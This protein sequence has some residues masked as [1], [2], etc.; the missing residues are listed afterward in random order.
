M[1]PWI[2]RGGAAMDHG[3]IYKRS[4]H[5]LDPTTAK[6]VLIQKEAKPFFKMIFYHPNVLLCIWLFFFFMSCKLV[7]EDVER[8][9]LELFDP[10]SG[11][12]FTT[13][14]GIW[15]STAERWIPQGAQGP[16][17]CRCCFSCVLKFG[18]DFLLSKQSWL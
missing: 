7:P 6:C 4:G 3:C 2:P 17:N 10:V 8:I 9:S 18:I 14:N 16:S 5:L 15:R 13:A 11:L 12:G 1:L